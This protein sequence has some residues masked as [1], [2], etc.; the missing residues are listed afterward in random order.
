MKPVFKFTPAFALLPLCG[1]AQAAEPGS[2]GSML[3]VLPGLGLVLGL[4]AVCAW[5]A[6]RIGPGRIAGGQAIKFVASQSVGSRERVVIVEVNQ[7]WLVLGV[8]PG[9]V[10]TLSQMDKPAA[11]AEAPIAS[12]N[13]FAKP[14]FAVWLEKALS[15]K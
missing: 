4:I 8:A 12:A 6:K 2:P 1:L 3:Q 10:S 15:K 13:Q 5:I 9:R 7:Q 14:P 11:P